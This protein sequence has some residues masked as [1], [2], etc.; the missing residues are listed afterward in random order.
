MAPDLSDAALAR[1]PD[2]DGRSGRAAPGERARDPAGGE[3]LDL[4]GAP[5]RRGRGHSTGPRRPRGN[6]SG[7]PG[8]RDRAALLR[9][10]R[11]NQPPWHR[12]LP[13]DRLA[14]AVYR[15]DQTLGGD[16]NRHL[17]RSRALSGPG[18]AS[19]SGGFLARRHLPGASAA[20]GS[21]ATDLLEPPNGPAVRGAADD[22]RKHTSVDARRTGDAR[23]P[24]GE[25]DWRSGR[26]RAVAADGGVHLGAARWRQCPSG[27]AGAGR[28]ERV[29]RITLR[30]RVS[31]GRAGTPP[32]SRRARVDADAGAAGR[33][34]RV[35]SSG[36]HR[37][38]GGL[39]SSAAF[40]ARRTVR[41]AP[42][43]TAVLA[44]VAGSRVAAV[45]TGLRR[46]RPAAS[47]GWIR[48]LGVR[49]DRRQRRCYRAGRARGLERSAP[50]GA[51]RPD[52]SRVRARPAGAGDNALRAGP[53]GKAP[54]RGRT[55]GGR[56]RRPDR[57]AGACRISGTGCHAGAD[58][59]H[60]CR[61]HRRARAPGGC[62]ARSGSGLARPRRGGAVAERADAAAPNRAARNDAAGATHGGASR[63]RG[64]QGRVCARGHSAMARGVART[65]AVGCRCRG[66]RSRCGPRGAPGGIEHRTAEHH[67]G[68]GRLPD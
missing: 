7:T 32:L 54:V 2:R 20:R 31:H 26:G 45:P 61:P 42:R 62:P 66:R 1:A 6:T 40:V 55:A 33:G 25:P 52:Q 47:S 10:Q 63:A 65:R 3:F 15:N 44:S 30:P 56:T 29:G 59:R 37:P 67:L 28:R 41:L 17:S 51:G 8:R 53:A 12:L 23:A 36:P 57:V 13:A 48:I 34:V 5:A 16:R 24:L 50:G 22:G 46:E 35:R 18:S 38:G 68:G 27:V 64:R 19:G 9:R 14:A 11:R 60:G 4:D 39:A 49:A 21:V 43:R 58:G